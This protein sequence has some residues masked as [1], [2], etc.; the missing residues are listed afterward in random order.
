MK[1]L[2]VSKY[3]LDKRFH[4]FELHPCVPDSLRPLLSS[5]AC[6]VLEEL[7][8]DDEWSAEG[9]DAEIAEWV[10][11]TKATHLKAY[12]GCIGPL[13]ASAFSSSSSSPIAPVLQVRESEREDA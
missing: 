13:T 8:L 10:T 1:A 4:S 6:E 3:T 7:R 11:R 12:T 5:G 9:Y 2:A